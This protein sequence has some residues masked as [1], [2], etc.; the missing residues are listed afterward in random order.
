MKNA[1]R[2]SR[3]DFSNFHP[4]YNTPIYKLTVTG[5]PKK[6]KENYTYQTA[7]D[8]QWRRT[9]PAR[10]T[11]ARDWLVGQPWNW[12]RWNTQEREELKRERELLKQQF[13]GYTP[14]YLARYT[15][16]NINTHIKL[17]PSLIESAN[18]Q[19]KLISQ[20]CRKVHFNIGNIHCNIENIHYS[21]EKI[22]LLL[23][24]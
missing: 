18:W 5:Y 21:M 22:H 17:N 2:F 20:L 3:L 19:V 1:I 13:Y 8:H 23:P 14:M 15:P 16:I 6:K 24:V 11:G 10:R 12:M 4:N 9:V 7:A